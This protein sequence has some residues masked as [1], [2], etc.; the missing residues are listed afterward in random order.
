MSEEDLRWYCQSRWFG[1]GMIARIISTDEFR[2]ASSSGFLFFHEA[3]LY[4]SM[5]FILE[6]FYYYPYY[7]FYTHNG[8]F[9]GR[10]TL[11]ELTQY[12]WRRNIFLLIVLMQSSLPLFFSSVLTMT[13]LGTP[14][15]FKAA[16]NIRANNVIYVTTLRQLE[17]WGSWIFFSYII[18][19]FQCGN[20]TYYA[21]Y[22]LLLLGISNSA[23]SLNF[24]VSCGHAFTKAMTLFSVKMQFMKYRM[25]DHFS[26][27]KAYYKRK[28]EENNER[29][30][31]VAVTALF[32]D[33]LEAMMDKTG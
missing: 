11:A 20:C 8:Y 6:F 18:W 31:A 19:Y 24:A 15:W 1:F 27:Y 25:S 12:T 16:L 13:T 32:V 17:S 26:K 33:L 28:C 4:Q 23:N 29:E 10:Y 21:S 3:V 5:G 30:V 14:K 22:V 7:Y 2:Y 9:H